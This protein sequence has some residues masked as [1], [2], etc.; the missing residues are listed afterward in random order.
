MFHAFLSKWLSY[1]TPLKTNLYQ[2]MYHEGNSN[3]LVLPMLLV[4]YDLVSSVPI[5]YFVCKYIIAL[6]MLAHKAI[7]VSN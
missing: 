4:F 1:L 7:K 5:I 6:L 2:K 3:F